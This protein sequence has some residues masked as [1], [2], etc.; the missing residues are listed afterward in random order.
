MTRSSLCNDGG[1]LGGGVWGWSDSQCHKMPRSMKFTIRPEQKCGR[2]FISVNYHK[3][4]H[5]SVFS[6]LVSWNQTCVHKCES[7]KKNKI[8]KGG[9]L[10][11]KDD[12]LPPTSFLFI[13]RDF[14][15]LV[16]FSK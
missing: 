2:A 7:K 13:L 10:S 9:T 4:K 11:D 3:D 6:L 14:P 12:F 8:K 1:E 15:F 5:T 16:Q